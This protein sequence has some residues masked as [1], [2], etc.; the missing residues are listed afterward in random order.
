MVKP[1]QINAT[2]EFGKSPRQQHRFYSIYGGGY[3]NRFSDS[4]PRAK[5]GTLTAF[6]S[7]GIGGFDLR[8]FVLELREI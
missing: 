8:P 3:P 1:K 6:Y 4:L 5:I 7:H 2:R